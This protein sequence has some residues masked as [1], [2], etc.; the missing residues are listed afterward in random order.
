MGYRLAPVNDRLHHPAR[1]RLAPGE[2]AG[3]AVAQHQV[4]DARC[5]RQAERG[6]SLEIT[7]PDWAAPPALRTRRGPMS[8]QRVG[9]VNI[10]LLARAR[11]LAAGR[12]EPACA[13]SQSL[14]ALR[15]FETTH[16]ESK[17]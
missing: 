7:A 13:V 12:V 10:G 11:H 16:L 5:R 3:E 17:L 1:L 9:T 2:R 14:P 6:A 4:L 8:P 15:G